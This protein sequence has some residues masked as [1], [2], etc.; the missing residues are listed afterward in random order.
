MNHTIQLPLC[1]KHHGIFK[2]QFIEE[3]VLAEEKMML[4][5]EEFK[6]ILIL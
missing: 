1:R 2:I 3:A 6:H 4:I 5:S